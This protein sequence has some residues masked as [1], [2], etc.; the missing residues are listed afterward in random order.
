[1]Y[2]ILIRGAQV[3]DGTG[4]PAFCADVAVKDGKLVMNP[5]GEATEVIDAAG[6]TLCPGFIDAHSH[7]DSI[8]G[9]EAGQLCKTS[10]GVTTELAG[11]CGTT[12]YP[13]STD[14]EKRD[15]LLKK[16]GRDIH[17]AQERTCLEHY[18]PWVNAQPKTAN[19]ALY[20]GHGSVRIS[21]MGFALRTPTAEELESMKGMVREAMEHGAMG[22]SSGL[23]Y[24]PSCYAD[25]DELV[26]LCKVVAEYGGTYATHMRSEANEVVE[27]V[28]E[29][30]RVAERA[31]C[32]LNI[33]HHKIAGRDNWG[34]SVQTLELIHEARAR[35]VDVTLDAY[36][37]TASSTGLNACLPSDFFSHG[38]DKMY[39][40]LADPAVRAQLKPRMSGMDSRLRHC[41]GW[42]GILVTVAPKTPAA[43][44]KTVLDYAAEINAD[45]F[46]AYF[47]LMTN[48]GGAAKAIYFT[49]SEEDLQRIVCDEN[50]VIGSDGVVRALNI[51][52]HPR[53]FGTFTKAIRY[54]VRD[55][56][57][58]TL[59]Q[60][61]HKMTGLTAQRFGLAT[62][63]VIADGMDADLL[64]FRPDEIRDHATYQNGLALSEGIERVIVAG[65][66][67][68][69]NGRLT[70]TCPG[71][72]LPHRG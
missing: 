60:M 7:G 30:I 68:Y 19:I 21:V 40:L 27:S 20:I 55:K 14:P 5:E 72:F 38:P 52:S 32:K 13:F 53:G 11:L 66:T 2:D 4:A 29:A 23:I 50:T 51:P 59:E 18:L 45:P 57:L 12:Y 9:T 71:V 43:V 49:M 42:G 31:G 54:F 61:I 69:Q 26:E 25:E 47:D 39:Q 62:K 15:M 36:P 1:M 33:S 37:Y 48:N 63:G 10:Q 70:G 46:D 58:L 3:I 34:R 35:G 6:L 67:V 44:N 22:M 41:G 56:G 28:R 24:A 16:L 64:L 65:Q 8:L 17:D